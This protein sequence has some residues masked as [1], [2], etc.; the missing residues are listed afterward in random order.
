MGPQQDALTPTSPSSIPAPEKNIVFLCS[1]VWGSVVSQRRRREG[2]VGGGGGEKGEG[3]RVSGTLLSFAPHDAS[4]PAY[5][6][7]SV[8]P[9]RVS[10][11]CHSCQHSPL[12]KSEVLHTT[13][14]NI[15]LLRHI[16]YIRV[17]KLHQP[18]SKSLNMYLS[19]KTTDRTQTL[20]CNS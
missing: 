18:C 6:S 1:K 20:F 14:Y 8:L 11:L 19:Y 12:R 15:Q 7:D 4:S 2:A 3:R 16:Q 5:N 9:S 13:S 10:E 17:S